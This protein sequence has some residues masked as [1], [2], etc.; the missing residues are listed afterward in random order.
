M[1]KHFFLFKCYLNKCMSESSSFLSN[2]IFP[3]LDILIDTNAN[4]SNWLYRKRSLNGCH[5]LI[6]E[7]SSSRRAKR[8]KRDQRYEKFPARQTQKSL[9]VF[10]C[11][12]RRFSGVDCFWTCVGCICDEIC[13]I[14]WCSGSATKLSTKLK[15]TTTLWWLLI[16]WLI[17]SNL[18][19]TEHQPHFSRCLE[20][21]QL[22]KH[23]ILDS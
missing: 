19:S 18:Q 13:S 17:F 23:G 14:C 1:G 8:S 16:W 12:H 7:T 3:P 10:W 22:S 15:C 11:F 5:L 9:K 4:V 6:G 20:T 2:T 21:F